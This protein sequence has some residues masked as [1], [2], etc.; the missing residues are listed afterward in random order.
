ME[1]SRRSL[2]IWF[3]VEYVVCIS[4]YVIDVSINLSIH[5]AIHTELYVRQVYN[6]ACFVKLVLQCPSPCQIPDAAPNRSCL[7]AA[8]VRSDQNLKPSWYKLVPRCSSQLLRT[9]ERP[10]IEHEAG[11]SWPTK[12][13]NIMRR[14]RSMRSMSCTSTIFAYITI[15]LASLIMLIM[16]SST[17]INHTFKII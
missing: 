12:D 5:P 14:M 11:S 4:F 17:Y 10:G 1:R 2:E 9:E 3:S 16:L 6:A 7:H 13:G 15:V 8:L